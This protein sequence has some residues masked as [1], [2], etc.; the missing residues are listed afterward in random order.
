MTKK[1]IASILALILLASLAAC[2]TDEPETPDSS[3]A[4][5]NSESTNDSENSGEN[6]GDETPLPEQ[7]PVN[8]KLNA[9]AKGI[10][11]LGERALSSEDEILCDWTGSGIE[12]V[13]DTNG[14]EVVFS[15]DSDAPCYF[16]AYING[17]E[18]KNSENSA[19]YKVDGKTELTLPSIPAGK[20]TITLI[21]VTDNNLAR[22]SLS[23][24]TVKG[25]IVETAP[26]DK[27]LYIEFVGADVA[28]G[29]GV[30]G[31]AADY[32]KQDGTYAY[33]YLVA[34]ALGADYAI[35]A[36]SGQGAKYNDN[37]S[38]N[39]DDGYLAASPIRN[40]IAFHD[41]TRKADAVVID[42]GVNDLANGVTADQFKTAYKRIVNTVIEKNGEDC[43]VVCVVSGAYADEIATVCSELG[44]QKSGFYTVNVNAP[45]GTYATVSE[46]ASLADVIRSAVDKALKGEFVGTPI[47]NAGSGNGMNVDIS[48]FKPM[49]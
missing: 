47:T 14:G 37:S 31:D 4:P 40:P 46:Q 13:L 49:A 21:K 7:K 3:D 27:E 38:Y 12:F 48:D 41:F 23:A 33:S 5:A 22:A 1:I 20:Q 28:A 30:L 36:L 26:A 34:K 39:L 6:G 18:W 17:I 44:G 11:L 19:Y 32:T 10:K 16:R 42:L 9:T 45:A 29:L 2:A 8:I 35:T 15:A 43:K 25:T 24:V